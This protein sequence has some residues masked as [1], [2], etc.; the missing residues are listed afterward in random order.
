MAA[1][2]TT[3]ETQPNRLRSALALRARSPNIDG[4]A[5]THIPIPLLL[6]ER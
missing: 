4:L 2:A 6:L 5:V 1:V 3:A